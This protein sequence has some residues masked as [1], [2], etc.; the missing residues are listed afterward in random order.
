MRGPI[1]FN[2]GNVD[3][4]LKKLAG[5]DRN[6]LEYLD[7]AYNLLVMY[8]TELSTIAARLDFTYNKSK[9]MAGK[10]EI[11]IRQKLTEDELE[12]ILFLYV[13]ANSYLKIIQEAINLTKKKVDKMK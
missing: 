9:T 3:N 1:T 2:F 8:S 11:L 13:N 6:E 12:E 10:R 7:E 5:Y 4:C